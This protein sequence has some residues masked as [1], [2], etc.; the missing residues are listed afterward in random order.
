MT[1]PLISQMISAYR[2]KGYKIWDGLDAQGKFKS[3]DLN[4]FGIRANNRDQ[5][6]DQ[7]DDLI[8]VFYKVTENNTVLKTWKGTTDPG[9]YF[10]NNPMNINGTFIMVPGQ[11]LGAYAIG[12]HHTHDALIQVGTLSG[13]RDGD[14]DNVLD[15]SP[16]SI[17]DGKNFG[18]NIHHKENDSETIGQG[19]A[20][21]QV[22]KSTADHENFMSLCHQAALIWGNSFTYT[23]FDE[24]DV[25]I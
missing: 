14:R 15:M 19:S 22:F 8:G 2:R 10:L 3:L 17:Y 25:F 11:Y 13:Y 21:C 12:K 24:N 16:G 20:G 4:I 18:V 6:Y 9:G 5:S 7:F 1:P 23:L